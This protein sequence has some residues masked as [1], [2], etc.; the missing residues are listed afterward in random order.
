MV[1]SEGT[2]FHNARGSPLILTKKQPLR[3]ALSTVRRTPPRPATCALLQYRSAG[4]F[5][6]TKASLWR[7]DVLILVPRPHWHGAAMRFP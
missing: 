6:V 3:L 5:C 4:T 1:P 7:I 2:F